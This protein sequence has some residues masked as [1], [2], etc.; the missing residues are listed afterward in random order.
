M[1]NLIILAGVSLIL[2][3][4]LLLGVGILISATSGNSKSDIRGGAVIFIGPIPIAFGTDRESLMT[5]SIL[6]LIMM[7]VFYFL[8]FR[9][10][11]FP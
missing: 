4:I 8:F 7:V 1:Q 6:M 11:R 10:F 2:I 5:L 9:S 3:G